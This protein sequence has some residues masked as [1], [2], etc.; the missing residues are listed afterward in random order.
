MQK[1][2]YKDYNRLPLYLEDLVG[3]TGSIN[4]YLGDILDVLNNQQM[5]LNQI[6]I[7]NNVKLRKANANIF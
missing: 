7:Y 5:Y 1:N 3:G 6:H 4:Q 2:I